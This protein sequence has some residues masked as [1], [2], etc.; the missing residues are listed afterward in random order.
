MYEAIKNFNKQFLYEPKIINQ[1]KLSKKSSFVVVGMGGSALAPLLLKTCK[2]KIDIIVHRD[3]GL[4]ELPTEELKNKLIILSSYSGN[5]EEI[6]DA[7]EK[8]KEKKLEMA[9]IATG[10]KLLSLAIENEIPYIE[11][12]NTGI[13]PRSALGYSMKAFLKI[14]DE[15]SELKKIEELAVVLNGND[16]DEN[17]IEEIGKALAQKMKNFVPIIYASDKNLSIAYNWKIKLNE[18]GKIPAFY[19]VL[20]ELNHNEMTGFDVKDS[21]KELNTKFFFII[22]KD[23]EDNEKVIKRMG[24]LEKLYK[25]RNLPVEVLELKGKDEWYKIFSSLM[26]ADFVAYYIAIGYGLEPEQ[27]PMVEEFKKLIS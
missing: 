1:K 15:E 26:L 20:P 27:V 13:Q 9:I 14:I 5:T 22:L 19:N 25:N 17:N 11:L 6:V 2:P 7:F 12:P 4:P 8:T 18:T 24:T 16:Y 3:Y 23:E 21:T 10:G